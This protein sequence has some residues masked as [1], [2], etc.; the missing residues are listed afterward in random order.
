MI[1]ARITFVIF[2]IGTLL[3]TVSLAALTQPKIAVGISHNVVVQSDGTIR[4]WGSND[5]GQLGDGSNADKGFPVAV[6]GLS[7]VLAV[8]GGAYYTVALLADG[9]VWTWGDN[10]KGQLGNG[11]TVNSNVP[12]MVQGLSGIT[13]VV[14]G[15][16]HT[17]AL[18]GNGVVFAW[19]SNSDGQI[20]NGNR[21]NSLFPVV[22]ANISGVVELAAGNN[23]S[24]AL[25]SDNTAWTWGANVHKAFISS[26]DRWVLSPYQIGSWD[27]KLTHPRTPIALTAPGTN[28]KTVYVVTG[29]DNTLTM[30]ADGKVLTSGMDSLS[31]TG[32][33]QTNTDTAQSSIVIDLSGALKVDISPGTAIAAGT[34]WRVDAGTWHLGGETENGVSPGDHIVEFMELGEWIS[35]APLNVFIT[36]GQLTVT[37]AV[38]MPQT[39]SLTVNVTPANATWSVDGKTWQA[40][41]ATLA[42]LPLGNYTITFSNLAEWLP[43]ED[44]SVTLGLDGAVASFA[45]AEIPAKLPKQDSDSDSDSKSDSDSTP[46]I[47]PVPDN[48]PTP[49]LVIVKVGTPVA[50]SIGNGGDSGLF[51]FSATAGVRYLVKVTDVDSASVKVYSF[52]GVTML[53]K[54]SDSAGALLWVAPYSGVFR[55]D[56]SSSDTTVT[57][58]F[59]ISIAERPTHVDFN[60]DGRSDVLWRNAKNGKTSIWLMNGTGVI[61]DGD[62]TMSAGKAGNWKIKGVEDFNGDGKADILW[63]NKKTGKTSIW[64]MDGRNMISASGLTASHISAASAW[65]FENVGDFDGDGKGD[66]LWRNAKSGATSIWFMDGLNIKAGSGLTSA[67]TPAGSAWHLKSVG[68]FN[69]DGKSDI[70]WRHNE[71]GLTAIWFMNGLALIEDISG[72]T[73]MHAGGGPNAWSIKGVGDF[74]GDG[75]TDVLW[76]HA[77]SGYTYIWLM[78]GSTV[79]FDSS[80]TSANVKHDSPWNIS[81]VGDYNGDGKSDILWERGASGRTF[82]WMMNGVEI[83]DG[84]AEIST[85]KNCEESGVCASV[86]R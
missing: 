22:V 64:F 77:G 73:S 39:A 83:I 49:D 34:R 74:N 5:L 40:S 78:D 80:Y 37:K 57:G 21:V 84:S 38:Y 36:E 70:L 3:P 14:A 2:L 33:T 15:F 63:R 58:S 42:S 24:Y 46:D 28:G 82:V 30:Q 71:T 17:L 75:K 6:P 50:G 9:T 56:I 18:A 69:G 11:T 53:S 54:S 51:S 48:D 55:L 41:G 25:Q 35:P 65:N 67:K 26:D 52:D 61:S 59:K 7:N 44:Q 32:A 60:G 47:K 86:K 76:R 20:G 12:V 31:Q 29:A 72:F 27:D 68:D 16:A 85:K 4:T 19:G 66:I 62:T 43:L 23:S 13:S 8:T 79:S 81:G 10:S 1:L 45:Y